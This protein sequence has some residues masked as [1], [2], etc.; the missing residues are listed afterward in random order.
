MSIHK[1]M[2]R[3][4]PKMTARLVRTLLGALLLSALAGT[5]SGGE[6]QKLVVATEG[7]YP[8]YNYVGTDGSLQGFD[9]DF[10]KALCIKIAADCTIIKQDWAGLIPGLIARKFDLIVAS[11]GILPDREA[12]IDFSIPYY[13]SPSAVV[14]SATSGITASADGE[15]DPA[16]MQGKMIGVQRATG[17]ETQAR[18]RWPGAKVIAYDSSDVADLDMI[19]GRLDARFDDYMLL[20]RG[21]LSSDRASAFKRVGKI[22]SER[23][24]GSKGQ[25]IGMRKGEAGLREAVNAAIRGMRADGSYKTINDR[26]FEFDIYGP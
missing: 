3:T 21:L 18:Q 13:Q 11:M 12:L 9:V 8:P 7:A 23:D 20:K 24:F 16:S 26:Y 4:F 15:I 1:I 2:P 6:R 25:G 10:A 14:A 22:W 19:K 5:A 17:Y